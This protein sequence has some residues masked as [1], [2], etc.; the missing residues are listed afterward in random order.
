MQSSSDSPGDGG[1]R[2]ERKLILVLY[3][4]GCD[5]KGPREM[6]RDSGGGGETPDQQTRQIYTMFDQ[7][8]SNVIDGR[9][10]LVKHWVDVSCFLGRE[11]IDNCGP[12]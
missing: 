12:Q 11:G 1:F 5:G 2:F 3:V 6:N 7:C 9:P 8:L 10:T 4:T